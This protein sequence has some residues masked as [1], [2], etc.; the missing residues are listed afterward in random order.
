L[1]NRKPPK[2]PD[3]TEWERLLE[4]NGHKQFVN[5]RSYSERTYRH[6]HNYRENYKYGPHQDRGERPRDMNYFKTSRVNSHS[7]NERERMT[8][9]D[10]PTQ[11]NNEMMIQEQEKRQ[12]TQT[13]KI[14]HPTPCND[15][16]I[17]HHVMKE[18]S[19]SEAPSCMVKQT[20]MDTNQQHPLPI[21]KSN[22]QINPSTDKNIS[23]T[24]KKSKKPRKNKRKNKSAAQQQ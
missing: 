9:E 15:N 12:P 8:E 24:Q 7:K 4:E 17:Q 1:P 3:L 11:K 22:D 18:L 16:E 21:A 10:T 20:T 13:K 5:P 23:Q 19:S 2:H 14:E 6:G